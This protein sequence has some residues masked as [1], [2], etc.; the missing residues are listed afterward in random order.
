MEEET[1][2]KKIAYL[3]KNTLFARLF[4]TAASKGEMQPVPERPNFVKN[5][6]EIAK[7][8]VEI[9]AFQT[10]LKMNADKPIF[11][12]YD[13]PPFATGKPHYGHILVFYSINF[14]PSFLY[15][16]IGW[17]NQ[18]YYHTLCSPNWT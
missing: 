9:D 6:E 8:W 5:E 18:R 10:S 17:D 14:A 3:N 7:L 1:S 11:N 16:L 15:S 4:T 12:F 2:Q 13:G